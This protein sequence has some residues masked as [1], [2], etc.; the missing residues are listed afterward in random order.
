MF[1]RLD[2]EATLPHQDGR[3]L[4]SRPQPCPR[5]GAGALLG[6]SCITHPYPRTHAPTHPPHSHARHSPSTRSRVAVSVLMRAPT[7]APA[8]LHLLLPSHQPGKLS[9]LPFESSTDALQCELSRRRG[10]LTW[11]AWFL[12]IEAAVGNQVCIGVR[13]HEARAQQTHGNE[14]AAG[15][16]TVDGQYDSGQSSSAHS[17]HTHRPAPIHRY[18]AVW[19][20]AR[21]PE[22]HPG[23]WSRA[24][25]N[26]K[27]NRW[28]QLP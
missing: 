9:S 22:S 19:V 23:E 7:P 6:K 15:A 2:F 18:G 10:G 26:Y 12:L 21:L 11:F 28:H 25:P 3:N 27:L 5:R 8:P 14:P 17:L 1:W 20:V 13:G 4:S 24:Q 16:C